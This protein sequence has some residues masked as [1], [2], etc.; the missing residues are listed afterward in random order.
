MIDGVELDRIRLFKYL[1]MILD[2]ILSFTEHINHLHKKLSGRLGILRKVRPFLNIKTRLLLYQGL[3]SSH[4]DYG[5]IIYCTASNENLRRLQVLQNAACQIILYR[6]I[7]SSIFKMHVDL[8]ILPLDVR[9]HIWLV[10]ECYKAVNFEKYSLQDFFV[11]VA[12]VTG[13][14][15]RAISNVKYVVPHCK[16][17]SG[18]KSFASRGPKLWNTVPTEYQ[19]KP[20]YESFKS[21]YLKHVKDIFFKEENHTFPT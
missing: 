12:R 19:N 7:T 16:T 10:N 20:W 18:K 5:D 14:C 15:T 8:D 6:D 2:E 3:I 17:D 21:S 11:P 13:P 9:H 4:F 1:G